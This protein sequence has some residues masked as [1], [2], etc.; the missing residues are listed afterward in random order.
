VTGKESAT[1]I[2]HSDAPGQDATVIITGVLTFDNVAGLYEQ[3]ASL[4]GP[5]SAVR[6]IDLS[7]V[8]RVDSAGLALLLEWQAA[9]KSHDAQFKIT[10]APA[11]LLSLAQLCEAQELLQLAARD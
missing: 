6:E 3:A 1:R 2:S 8:P 4:L 11:D 5:G 10:H 7:G 9:A